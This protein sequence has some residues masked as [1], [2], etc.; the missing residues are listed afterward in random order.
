MRG[1]L[2]L[3]DHSITS[4]IYLNNQL[5]AKYDNALPTALVSIDYK[6]NATLNVGVQ[7]P[8]KPI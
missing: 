3:L 4:L 5:N 7:I 6:K 2:F 1:Y 8:S